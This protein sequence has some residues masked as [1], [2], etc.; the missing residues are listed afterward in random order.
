[1]FPYTKFYYDIAILW[2]LGAE[3]QLLHGQTYIVPYKFQI[4]ICKKVEFME[5]V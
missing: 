3:L 2:L 1:M 4:I 5:Y